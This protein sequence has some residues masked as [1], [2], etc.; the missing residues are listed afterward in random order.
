VRGAPRGDAPV[1]RRALRV[2]LE[3]L[4]PQQRVARGAGGG[5]RVLVRAQLGAVRLADL[6]LAQL[7]LGEL[8]CGRGRRGSAGEP[9]P[10][11]RPIWG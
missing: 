7:G 6:A 8:V 10:G 11:A 3:A 9:R 1:A 2:V 4:T 5:A